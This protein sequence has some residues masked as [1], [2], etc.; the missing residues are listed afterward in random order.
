[1][2]SKVSPLARQLQIA[3]SFN[4]IGWVLDREGRLMQALEKFDNAQ[5][6]TESVLGKD[7][8]RMGA[9]LN[10]IGMVKYMMGKYDESYEILQK[11]YQSRKKFQGKFHYETARSQVSLGQTHL[12]LSQYAKAQKLLEKSLFIRLNAFGEMHLETTTSL[13]A[14]GI[15]NYRLGKH[16]EATTFL[17]KAFDIRKKVLE[18]NNTSDELTSILCNMGVV[19]HA[20][21][22]H[23]LSQ[24]FYLEALNLEKSTGRKPSIRTGF[25]LNNLGNLLVENKMV[26]DSEKNHNEFLAIISKTQ[27]VSQFLYSIHFNN[28]GV[29]RACSANYQDALNNFRIAHELL[30]LVVFPKKMNYFIGASLANLAV[31]YLKF[32][33][34]SASMKHFSAAVDIYKNL[35]GL[36]H[37]DCDVI[38]AN[39]LRMF[40]SIDNLKTTEDVEKLLVKIGYGKGEGLA[41]YLNKK[42]EEARG[43]L[44]SPKLE[45][46][47]INLV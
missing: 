34:Y 14:L 25:I 10:N 20:N 27:V 39:M 26:I 18:N 38:F 22:N 4:A 32:K 37:P 1:M 5:T 3:Q 15:L 13:E 2:E 24:T 36:L 16:E 6:L 23:L 46:I 33:D 8:Y 19:E 12:M 45:F 44:P 41:Q 29:V 21:G 28:M 40:Q 31:M 9:L 17:Q 11:A 35:F 30:S 43:G 7:N 47:Y 42:R